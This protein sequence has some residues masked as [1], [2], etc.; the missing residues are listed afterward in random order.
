MSHKMFRLARLLSKV[1]IGGLA[2]YG[3]FQIGV[4]VHGRFAKA[5]MLQEE[6]SC[7]C[8]GK[9]W[10]IVRPYVRILGDPSLPTQSDVVGVEMYPSTPAQCPAIVFTMH[11]GKRCVYWLVDMYPIHNSYNPLFFRVRQDSVQVAQK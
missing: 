5:P 1:M 10:Q 2:A 9:T 8:L 6:G 3:L 4:Q 7:I 11:D